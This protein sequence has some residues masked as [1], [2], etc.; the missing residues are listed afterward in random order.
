MIREVFIPVAVLEVIAAAVERVVLGTPG[1]VL[2]NVAIDRKI[3]NFR[4]KM[5][6]F[7]LHIFN[8]HVSL[9]YISQDVSDIII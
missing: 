4:L 9:L 8:F 6:S 3:T 2:A 7:I 1:L 5:N